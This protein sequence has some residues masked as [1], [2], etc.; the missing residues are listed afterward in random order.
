[1]KYI[2]GIFYYNLL[3][4][5]KAVKTYHNC[6]NNELA[7]GHL[8]E[9][10]MVGKRKMWSKDQIEEMKIHFEKLKE[11]A[12]ER[13]VWQHRL[14]TKY[15][16]ETRT[17]KELGVPLITLRSW[18]VKGLLPKKTT[19]SPLGRILVWTRAEFNQIKRF[20]Q[21][22]AKPDN[23]T[24]N[25]EQLVEETGRQPITLHKYKDKLGL[26]KKYGNSW[27][28]THEEAQILRNYVTLKSKK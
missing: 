28:L 27:W 23:Y 12:A 1:M 9:P 19:V 17:A 25:M 16:T 7:A 8:P 13:N 21:K 4:A 22:K 20:V 15:Y 24:V 2:D 6:F 10:M 26:G 11:E 14:D 18:G 5:V 3:E